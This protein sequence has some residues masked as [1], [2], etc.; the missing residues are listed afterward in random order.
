MVD[1]IDETAWQK[2][3]RLRPKLSV[4]EQIAHLKFKGV[5]FECCSEAEAADYLC[6]VSNYTHSACYR[7]L[8][9]VRESGSRA[10][11][12]IGLDF[13]ALISLSS[14]DRVLRSSL[15]EICIDVE[16]FSRQDLLRRCDEHGE[17]GYSIVADYFEEKESKGKARL[18]STL[19]ARS[20]SGKYPDEYSGDLISHYSDDLGAIPD[21]VLLEVSDFG[22]F[23]DFW[24]FCANRWN[25]KSMLEIHYVLKSVKALRN[26]CSHNACII[27]GFVAS[28]IESDYGTPK[29]I[30]SSMNAHGIRNCKSRKKKMAN[31]RI[32]QIA[33]T[34]FASSLFCTRLSTRTRHA[35]AMQRARVSLADAR[36]LFPA[37]GSLKSYFD[38]LFKLVDIWM[39]LQ[40]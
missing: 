28:A 13:A 2:A 18:S 38:F 31:L 32:S 12:Y 15:R 21:W 22:S 1:K 39:P 29:V 14:A 35:K 34:L 33:A 17:D 36:S 6:N 10:G 3:R 40:A 27:N 37:D 7:K 20:A 9:A 5:S 19:K 26:A 8:Y 4:E 11:E 23:V 25:D 30:T 24:M 16:H